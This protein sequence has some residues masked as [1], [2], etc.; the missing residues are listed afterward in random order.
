LTKGQTPEPPKDQQLVHTSSFLLYLFLAHQKRWLALRKEAPKQDIH[1]ILLNLATRNLDGL[2]SSTVI[3]S[4][5]FPLKSFGK[6]T[7]LFSKS[8]IILVLF[9]LGEFF[10]NSI[11]GA[12]TFLRSA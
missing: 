6:R 12:R 5:F 9:L 2:E 8:P 1:L 4:C 7:N 3:I 10:K 11:L